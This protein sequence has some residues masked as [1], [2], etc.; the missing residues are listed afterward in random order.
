MPENTL[1]AANDHKRAKL[2]MP[3]GASGKMRGGKEIVEISDVLSLRGNENSEG[4]TREAPAV[5]ARG[6]L[7]ALHQKSE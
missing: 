2:R 6:Y 4:S 7:G 5:K 1:N 3:G